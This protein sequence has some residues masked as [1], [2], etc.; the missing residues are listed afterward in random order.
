M[1]TLVAIL[2][3]RL[4]DIDRLISRT[5]SYAV[6]TG[7]LV[8]VYALVVTGVTRLLPVSSSQAVA[9]A[10]LAAAA[11][12]QPLRRRLQSAVDRRFN[13]ARYDAAQTVEA[14]TVRLRDEVDLETV[15][16]DLLAVVGQTL[17]PK[18]AGLWLRPG[19]GS[20]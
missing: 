19:R 17:E 2:R 13:R 10:T 15:R 1:A 18:H 6:L 4:Y 11:L 5:F 8:G 14:F 3:Y 9:V 12:F 16:V 20:P 7:L